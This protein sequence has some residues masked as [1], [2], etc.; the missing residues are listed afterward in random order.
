MSKRNYLLKFVNYPFSR[1]LST[2]NC[3]NKEITRKVVIFGGNGYVGQNIIKAKNYR[4]VYKKTNLFKKKL[5]KILLI[6]KV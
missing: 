1:Y 5:S 4:Q 3:D 2:S 6:A